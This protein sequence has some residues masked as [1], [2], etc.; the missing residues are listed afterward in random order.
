[1]VYRN[2]I[3]YEDTVVDDDYEVIPDNVVKLFENIEDENT[4]IYC[5]ECMRDTFY[6]LFVSGYP[7]A[8][9]S[10]CGEQYPL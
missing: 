5:D 1:M 8:E 10:G 4:I 9:C 2:L 3:Y 7:W 6:V